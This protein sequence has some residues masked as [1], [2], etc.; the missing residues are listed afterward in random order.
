MTCANHD[1]DARWFGNQVKAPV[2]VPQGSPAKAH[3][4]AKRTF[5]D[6]ELLGGL[7]AMSCGHDGGEMWVFWR[8]G[9]KRLLFCGDTI[10]GQT[11]PDG[12]AGYKPKW[13]MQADGI[14]LYRSGTLS[15]AEMRDRYSGLLAMNP[16]EVFNG[17]NPRS[18]SNAGEAIAD[19]LDK[20][21]LEVVKGAG[22]YLWRRWTK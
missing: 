18:I 17:H 20:G 13:W 6:E 3:K 21:K 15:R 22:T 12:L 5:G 8:L 4:S 14:R 2:L 9:R 7:R 10:Y 19:V 1:R 11:E 16:T